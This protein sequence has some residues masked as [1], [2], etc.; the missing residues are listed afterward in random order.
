MYEDGK[1]R[2]MVSSVCVST[3]LLCLKNVFPN[4]MSKTRKLR[5]I[6]ADPKE[7]VREILADWT[8]LSRL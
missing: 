5:L 3:K 7:N 8:S 4:R 6:W 2:K 1:L